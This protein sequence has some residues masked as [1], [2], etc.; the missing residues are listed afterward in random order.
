VIVCCVQAVLQHLDIRLGFC[1]RHNP[2]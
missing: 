1:K 2:R